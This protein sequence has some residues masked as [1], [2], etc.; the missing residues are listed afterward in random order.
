MTGDFVGNKSY[1]SNRVAVRV[2]RHPSRPEAIGL[3]EFSLIPFPRGKPELFLDVF[4]YLSGVS[5]ESVLDGGMLPRFSVERKRSEI[6][7]AE[8]EADSIPITENQHYLHALNR[9]I[10]SLPPNITP[11]LLTNFTQFAC[12]DPGPHPFVTRGS[13]QTKFG[14][15]FNY[16]CPHLF[17]RLFAVLSQ[18][19]TINKL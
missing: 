16:A 12:D 8:V 10:S 13:L 5:L 15:H 7:A 2:R 6:W 9:A 1:L 4:Q 17:N 19:R 14:A 18:G 3:A 11:T